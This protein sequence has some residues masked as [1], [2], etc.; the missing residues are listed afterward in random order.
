VLR[1][2][3]SQSVSPEL[4]TDELKKLLVSREFANAERL[5]RLLRYIVE[6][7]L[8][9]DRDGLKESVI[10]VEVFDRP[11]DYDPK[12][13]PIVRTEARRLRAR[14]DEYYLDPSRSPS[15]RILIPK[16]G[17]VALFDFVE[18]VEGRDAAPAAAPA[19]SPPVSAA[20]PRRRSPKR[21][22][23]ALISGI[24]A[25]VVLSLLFASRSHTPVLDRAVPFTTQRGAQSLPH[26]SPS[27]DTLAFDWQAPDDLH[28][29]IYVQRLDGVTPSRLTEGTATERCPTWSPDGSRIAFLRAA[30]PSRW[31]IFTRA[32]AGSGERKWAELTRDATAAWLDWS[33]DGKWFAFAEPLAPGGPPSIVAVSLETGERRVI[34]APPARGRGDGLPAFTPDSSGIVFRRTQTLS[35]DEDLFAIPLAGGTL[36]RLTFDRRGISGFAFNPDGSL[37]FSSKRTGTIR[38]LWWMHPG[39]GGLRRLTSAVADATFPSVS[40]NGKHFAFTRVV[41][42]VNIWRV[43]AD[44]GADAAPLIDSEL[45]DSSAQFSP[46]GQRIVFQSARSGSAEIWVCSKDGSSVA[47]LTDGTGAYQDNPRWSPDGKQVALEWQKT[48]HAGIYLVGG[49][50]GPVRTLAVGDYNNQLPSWSQDGRFVYFSSDRSGQPELWKAPI[51]GGP[52]VKMTGNPGFAT[53]ES[54]DRKYLYWTDRFTTEIWRQPLENGV[55]GGS[56]QKVLTNLHAGDWGL[57]ALGRYG[58]YYIQR[59]QGGAP[60]IVYRDLASGTTRTIHVLSNPPVFGNGGLAVSPDETVVLFAQ[61]DRDSENIFVQ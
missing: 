1:G 47:R 39:G 52:Q 29:R 38:S 2:Q 53:A 8:A 42:D 10:G 27:G 14:L 30:G 33:P 28:R 5:A 31:A 59:Q 57:W 44:G 35:G 58:I 45:S 17:Y 16:G 26:L 6:H 24:A 19:E 3:E 12:S 56:P 55:L 20:S 40:R 36:R 13:E 49:D 51:D 4:V 60:S 32:L 7:T 25:A 11:A 18:T 43:N 23:A 50:G 34:T 9:G 15:V 54:Q 46:D 48:G 21:R 61:V 37:I 41:A 22:A